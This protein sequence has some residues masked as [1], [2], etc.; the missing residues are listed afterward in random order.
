MTAG[1]RV[2]GGE[3]DDG[4]YDMPPVTFAGWPPSREARIALMFVAQKEQ[5]CACVLPVIWPHEPEICS[6]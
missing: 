6:A 4:D 2:W 3:G 1:A 5:A